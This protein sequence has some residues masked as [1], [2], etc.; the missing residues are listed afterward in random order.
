MRRQDFAFRWRRQ[1][2]A[3]MADGGRGRVSVLWLLAA[4][5]ASQLALSTTLESV[6]PLWRD[7]EFVQKL[8]LLRARK[9][10]KPGSPVVVVF[11]SSRV[12]MG[13]R[14]AEAQANLPP[15]GPPLLFNGALIGAGPALQ[16]L[17]LD[18]LLRAGERPDAIVV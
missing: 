15:P 9:G 4:F 1:A 2:A 11:G 10:D 5:L 12:Y 14:P 17:T 16:L 6:V 7:P 3:R 18:R 8:E 13:F